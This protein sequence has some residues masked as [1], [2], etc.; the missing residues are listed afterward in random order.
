MSKIRQRRAGISAQ[1]P[2]SNAAGICFCISVA[3]ET[4]WHHRLDAT[5]AIADANGGFWQRAA[6][7]SESLMPGA[8]IADARQ[9]WLM[10]P[11]AIADAIRQRA[12]ARAA[13]E[14]TDNR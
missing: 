9:R 12:D 8:A 13:R 5:A 3:A 6:C 10:P 7:I 2:G 1:N 4:L 11:A 14:C